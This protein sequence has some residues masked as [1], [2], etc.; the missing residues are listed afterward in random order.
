MLLFLPVRHLKVNL[1]KI[2]LILKRLLF[3]AEFGC[4]F[5]FYTEN[6]QYEIFFPFPDT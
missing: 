1:V 4:I 2:S 6:K 3:R 5:G